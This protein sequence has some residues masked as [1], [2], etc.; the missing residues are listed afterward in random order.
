MGL[1]RG[2]FG[3]GLAQAVDGNIRHP[4]VPERGDRLHL[5]RGLKGFE[6]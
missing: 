3:P 1:G 6:A 2:G 5:L 4:A